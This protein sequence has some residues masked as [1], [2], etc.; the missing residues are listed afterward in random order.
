MAFKFDMAAIQRLLGPQAAGDLNIFLEKLPQRAGQTALIA[1]GVAWM[2]GAGLGLYTS[3]QVRSLTELSAKLKEVKALKPVVP[4]IKDVPV[5]QDEVKKFADDMARTYTGLSVK[6][7]GANIQ[8]TAKSTALF[9]VFREAVGHVQ[10]GGQGWRVSVER[11]CVGRECD[12]NQLGV[13]LRINKVSV[14]KPT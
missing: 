12:Q 10:N 14:D 3:V 9:G 7:Q 13:L 4:K 11:M 8:I 2:A 5:P 6:Q 1:A